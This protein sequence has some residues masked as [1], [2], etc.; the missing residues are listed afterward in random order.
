VR[1]GP[2]ERAEHFVKENALTTFVETSAKDIENVEFAFEKLISQI[3]EE[4]TVR[5]TSHEPEPVPNP[6]IRPSGPTPSGGVSF[7]RCQK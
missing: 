6:T 1:E 3:Y 2:S 4:R 7:C 5:P